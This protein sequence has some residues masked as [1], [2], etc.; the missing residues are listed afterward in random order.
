MDRLVAGARDLAGRRAAEVAV[1]LVTARDVDEE[2]TR[3]IAR[4]IEVAADVV[5]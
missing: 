1:V 4:E 5:P 2:L 3:E